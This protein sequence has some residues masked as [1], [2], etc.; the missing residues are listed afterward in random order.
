M[1]QFNTF[2]AGLNIIIFC[3]GEQHTAEEKNDREDNLVRE[4]WLEGIE[5]LSHRER[6]NAAA[7]ASLLLSL[8]SDTSQSYNS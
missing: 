8:D 4:V 1:T 2:V 7:A 5:L 6:I 3:I